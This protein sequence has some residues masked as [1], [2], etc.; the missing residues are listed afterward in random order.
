MMER[1]ARRE[2]PFDAQPPFEALR[3]FV[4]SHQKL[5]V[6]STGFIASLLKLP[7][8]EEISGGVEKHWSDDDDD[9][10]DDVLYGDIISSGKNLEGL[11]SSSSPLTSLDLAAYTLSRADLCHI[12]RAP[13]ALKTLFFKVCK[14]TT[15]N[16]TD[17]RHA[18]VPQ[19]NCLESLDLDCDPGCEMKIEVFGSMTSFISFNTLKV[20]KAAALFF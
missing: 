8:I 10:D 19:E 5:H 15:V 20:L 13:K 14:P 18:L 16:F 12:L 2:K 17:L 4:I 7:A 9:D 6:R 11:D 3:V 1:A